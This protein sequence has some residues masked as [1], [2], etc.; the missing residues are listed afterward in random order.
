MNK[1]A[2]S[3]IVS[4]PSVKSERID[5]PIPTKM[6]NRGDF[7]SPESPP[8]Y[9]QDVR[10]DL[11]PITI[12]TE[13]RD[14][15]KYRY[16]SPNDSRRPY[17]DRSDRSDRSEREHKY[18]DYRNDDYKRSY[19]RHRRSRSR[20]RSRSH[21][22]ERKRYVKIKLFRISTDSHCECCRSCQFFD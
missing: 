16:D 1:M 7:L 19:D 14:A 18:S 6:E 21:S 22:Y 12:P 8:M 11:E 15:T 5:S 2:K 10:S 13:R 9:N 4:K 3:K 17:S 20:S